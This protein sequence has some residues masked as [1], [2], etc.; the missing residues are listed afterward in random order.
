MSDFTERLWPTDAPR[1]VGSELTDIPALSVHTSTSGI[2]SG[3]GVLICPGGGYRILASTHEGLHVAHALNQLGIRAFVLRYRV[4]PTYHS[5]TS[6]LDGQRAMRYI[7]HHADEFGIDPHR[8]GMLGFSAG[9]HLTLAVGTSNGQGDSDAVDPINRQ[10]A[11]PSFLVPI[12]A[13]SNG[14]VRGRKAEEYLPTDTQVNGETPP[15]FIVHTH[16]D[17]IVPPNQATLFYDALLRAGV[18]SELHIF[19][20]GEHGV[21]LASGDPDT[22]EWLPLLHR[23]LRRTN[24]LTP[25]E[26]VGIDQKFTWHDELEHPLGMFW[27]TL[28]PDD[29]NAPVARTRLDPNADE[30][31]KIPV[32]H[33]PIPGPHTLEVRRVTH[34][35]PYDAIGEYQPID[36]V[37]PVSDEKPTRSIPV[38]VGKDGVIEE[39]TR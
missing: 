37:P 8:L 19:G 23:W 7:R 12:Y 17:A 9:G 39:R 38:V 14:I 20:F 31:I 32:L 33:G 6:L 27:V 5:T 4:G 1:A 15:T 24:M 34:T 2:D 29:R 18:Q 25:L 10:S 22:R 3:A 28:I 35:W 21:G 13:V 16:E 26:R 36:K 30:H 11:V